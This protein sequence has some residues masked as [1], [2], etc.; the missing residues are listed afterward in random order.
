MWIEPKVDWSSGDYCTP[1]DFNRINGN[2]A[3]LL[4]QGEPAKVYTNEI[5]TLTEWRNI[6]QS[7]VALAQNCKVPYTAI[8]D[9]ITADNFNA[10]ESLMADLKQPVD[11]RYN[12]AKANKYAGRLHVGVPY[13]GGIK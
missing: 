1:D 9:Q 4:T 13:V 2:L 6:R 7:A 8:S 10:L 11:R 5:V 3:Y 12:M